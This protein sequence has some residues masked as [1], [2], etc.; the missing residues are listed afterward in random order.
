MAQE[1][2][3]DYEINFQY[4][5]GRIIEKYP[6]EYLKMVQCAAEKNVSDF[7]YVDERIIKKCP[8]EYLKMVQK[9]PKT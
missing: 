8:E 4:V 7:L 5:D 2:I 3:E 1:A 6:E 9:C